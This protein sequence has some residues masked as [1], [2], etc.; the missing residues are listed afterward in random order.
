M[1]P[2]TIYSLEP[3]TYLTFPNSFNQFVF[4]SSHVT[5]QFSSNDFVS[6]TLVL[7]TVIT[8][9]EVSDKRWCQTGGEWK[10]KTLSQSLSLFF[11]PRLSRVYLFIS[12]NI[13]CVSNASLYTSV[14]GMKAE[15]H[16]IFLAS[17]YFY[18]SCVWNLILS[19][20]PYQ[21][22]LRVYS[23]FL[24]RVVQYLRCT[25]NFSSVGP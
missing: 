22:P 14:N 8:A 4:A 18:S 23:S 16:V 1:C 24:R 19:V 9:H 17:K 13:W 15:L 11:L 6:D 12:L 3:L 2:P 21:A 5:T 7:G 20:E 10:T 25:V